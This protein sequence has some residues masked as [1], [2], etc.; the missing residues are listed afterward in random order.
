MDGGPGVGQYSEEAV[1]EFPSS[2][3]HSAVMSSPSPINPRRKFVRS[4]SQ[5]K[6]GW[7]SSLQPTQQIYNRSKPTECEYLDSVF[8]SQLC[9][10]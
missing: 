1:E 5:S 7:Q 8:Y 4:E 2:D 9:P 6:S 10:S 3:G